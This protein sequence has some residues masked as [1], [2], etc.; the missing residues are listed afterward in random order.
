MTIEKALPDSQ[1]KPAKTNTVKAS[2]ATAVVQ[3]GETRFTVE[4]G[5]EDSESTAVLPLI[6]RN[7]T[8]EHR[9]T[10]ILPAHMSHVQGDGSVANFQLQEALVSAKPTEHGVV[11]S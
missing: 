10:C 6:L 1:M 4:P 8:A 7:P 2:R 3:A 5:E 11:S 9:K